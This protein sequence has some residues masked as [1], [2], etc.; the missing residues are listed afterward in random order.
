[1]YSALLGAY[2]TFH[3][4]PLLGSSPTLVV[5]TPDEGKGDAPIV[6]TMFQKDYS[7]EVWRLSKIFSI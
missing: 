2:F 5:G 1:M 4:L 7:T 3:P 6:P